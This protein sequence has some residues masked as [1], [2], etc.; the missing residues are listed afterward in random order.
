MIQHLTV[1]ERHDEARLDIVPADTPTLSRSQAQHL[2]A[3]RRIRINDK[4]P[5]KA[6]DRLRTGDR[7]TVLTEPKKNQSPHISQHKPLN[8]KRSHRH[9]L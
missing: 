9:I 4:E 7:L 6:G 8:T 1:E 3:T 2:I 5:K